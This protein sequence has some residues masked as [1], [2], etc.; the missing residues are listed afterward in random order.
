MSSSIVRSSALRAGLAFLVIGILGSVV[1][2]YLLHDITRALK[3]ADRYLTVEDK[4]DE[5]ERLA[6]RS[7]FLDP[8]NEEAQ[9]VLGTALNRQ[10]RFEEAIS[11]FLTI[12]ESSVFYS[13]AAYGASVCLMLEGRYSEAEELLESLVK[14]HPHFDSARE[15]LRTLYV[16]TFRIDDALYIVTD[17]FRRQPQDLSY[18]PIVLKTATDF[19]LGLG[20]EHELAEFDHRFPGQPSIVAALAKA[21]WLKGETDK[22]DHYFHEVMTLPNLAV[23]NLAWAS[24]FWT[25]TGNPLKAQAALTEIEALPQAGR[26]L[27]HQEAVV[28]AAKAAAASA[29]QDYQ[30]AQLYLSRA[31][32]LSSNEPELYSRRATARRRLGDQSGAAEDTSAAIRLGASAEELRRLATRVRNGELSPSL[33]ESVAARLSE[34]GDTEFAAAWNRLGTALVRRR[35]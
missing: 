22:A 3:Q 15:M 10:K 1:Y 4:P 24:Q 18:L 13:E 32:D 7:L 28:L 27:P 30:Q 16:R 20:I 23:Q 5:A 11:A 19:P 9:I 29:K 35:P 6:R 21:Y 31:I 25:E 33:C 26:R 17:R 14:S 2:G 34:Q 8:G 12:P